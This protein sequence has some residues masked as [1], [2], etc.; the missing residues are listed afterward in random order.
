[1]EKESSQNYYYRYKIKRSEDLSIS[2]IHRRANKI[3]QNSSNT[4]L[5]DWA[6]F[7]EDDFVN[8]DIYFEP[9]FLNFQKAF[10]FSFEQ[11]MVLCSKNIFEDNSLI[12]HIQVKRFDQFLK[13]HEQLLKDHISKKINIHFSPRI[14]KDLNS[15]ANK[16]FDTTTIQFDSYFWDLRSYNKNVKGSLTIQDIGSFFNSHPFLSLYSAF[17]L[18]PIKNLEIWND[19]IPD[20]YE[21]EPCTDI[22]WQFKTKQRDIQLSIIIPSF[23]NS[24]FLINVIE[25]LIQQDFSQDNYEIIVVEDGGTDHSSKL[26][27]FLFVNLADQINLKFIYWSKQHPLQGDQNFFRAGLARNLGVQHS[28]SSLLVFLDS[29]ILVPKNFV[30]TCYHHLKKSDIIQFQRFHIHQHLSLTHPKYKQ[31]SLAS[32]TYIEEKNYWAQLF[33]CNQWDKL[34]NYWKFTCTYALGLKKNDFLMCGRFKKYYVSYG[35]EDTDLGYEMHRR[36]KKFELVKIPVF[37]LT[38][39]DKMQYKNSFSRRINLLQKTASLFYLQH[40][41]PKIFHTLRFFFR[42]EKPLLNIIKDLL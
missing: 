39:H 9:L 10:L 11:F 42:F 38:A 36:N 3:T 19:Q 23:N 40:L 7:T 30:S 31:I 1:M 14:K 34:E 24:K 15:F 17:K 13:L 12:I 22:S 18:G 8:L 6:D 37:H 29:D 16:T 21:L 41:D 25:H 2:S 5:F 4:I 26:I 28:E 32:N 33:F 27:Q 20:H 35:F